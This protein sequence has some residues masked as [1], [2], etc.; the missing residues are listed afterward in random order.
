MAVIERMLLPSSGLQRLIVGVLMLGLLA[1]SPPPKTIVIGFVGGLSGRVA[2]L[3]VEGRNGATLAVELR[4][5]AGGVKG[6]QVELLAEDDQQDPDLARQ[7]VGK[8]IDLKALAIIGP[9]TSAMAMATVPLANQAQML[10]VSP[11]VTTN[12]LTGI[13][14]YFFRVLAP[15]TEFA[16]KS[17]DYHFKHLG[18][19]RVVAAFDLSNRSYSESWLADYRAAFDAAGGQIV[20]GVGFTSSDQTLFADL[21]QQLLAS[22]PDG[23]LILANSVDAAMLCQNLR[24]LDAAI[25]ITTSEWAATEQLIELGGSSVEGIVV[26][27]FFDRHGTQ[28]A[29]VEFRQNYLERFGKEPGFAGLTAFDATNVV[30]DGLDGQAAGQTLKQSLL[31]RKAF[32]GVQSAVLFNGFGDTL[33]DTYLATVK[34]GSFALLQ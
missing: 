19:R 30:L 18:L 33:R 10:M 6:R 14:D 31:A 15:T 23:V 7:A 27:Q 24:K 12:L 26:G 2:D 29:Y 9:M 5:K 22:R 32:A 4:N 8:L 21:A 28:K 1:C 11:T 20:G 16:K 3:G 25:Q 13:D 17:A 34:N